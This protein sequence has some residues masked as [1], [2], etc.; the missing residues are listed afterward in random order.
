[1][2]AIQLHTF[3]LYNA[4]FLFPNNVTCAGLQF[5]YMRRRMFTSNVLFLQ[6]S[7]PSNSSFSILPTGKQMMCRWNGKEI[8]CNWV[9]LIRC[10][11]KLNG[12]R[13]LT[14]LCNMA[15]TTIQWRL[16]PLNCKCNGKVLWIIVIKWSSMA[17]YF[18]I[19]Q[20]HQFLTISHRHA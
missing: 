7:P 9:W 5:V 10:A 6:F 12:N 17:R 16:P 20:H 11:D 14:A 13:L 15:S 18:M 2:I 1:M 4:T 3:A 8:E 19:C